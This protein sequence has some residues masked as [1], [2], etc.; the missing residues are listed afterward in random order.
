[1]SEVSEK[2]GRS[3]VLAVLEFFAWVALT[4]IAV[5]AVLVISLL[6]DIDC[7]G[8]WGDRRDEACMNRKS[9]MALIPIAVFTALVAIRV[10]IHQSPRATGRRGARGGDR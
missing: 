3:R 7:N 4:V 8:L 9:W 5:G 1:V 10:R 2:S 6:V